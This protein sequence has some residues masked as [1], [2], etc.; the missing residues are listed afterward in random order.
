MDKLFRL[1]TAIY[2]LVLT[3]L[4]LAGTAYGI[5]KGQ[6][7]PAFSLPL[8]SNGKV[9]NL[10]QYRGKV[11]Y[12]DFWASWCGPCRQS[13]PLLN[14]LRNDLKQ[15]GFEVLAVN[16][17]EEKAAAQGFLDRF[18]VDYPILLDPEGGVAMQYELPGMP[19]SFILDKKGR[20]QFVHIGFKPGDMKSIE[21]QVK[22]LL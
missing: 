14:D 4:C 6:S 18:P 22:S 5:E 9:V 21:S 8:L 7:A 3:S 15:K 11:V 13:L 17:D 16:L 10:K 19:T 2:T 20:I 1:K 12:L